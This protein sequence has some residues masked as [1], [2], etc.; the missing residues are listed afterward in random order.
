MNQIISQELMNNLSHSFTI[1]LISS[2]S[3]ETLFLRMETVITFLVV[4][5]AVPKA[6][7]EGTNTYATF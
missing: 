7:F 2:L 4:P 1:L 6:F 3:F 5:Q